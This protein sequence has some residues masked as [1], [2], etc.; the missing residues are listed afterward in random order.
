MKNY[1]FFAVIHK[2]ENSDYGVQFPDV[3]GCFSAGATREE[4]LLMAKEALQEHLEWLLEDGM[5]LPQSRMLSQTVVDI[6]EE[7]LVSVER[8]SIDLHTERRVERLA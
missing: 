3:P 6:E 7:G 5:S 1:T 4:V 8:V 2:D